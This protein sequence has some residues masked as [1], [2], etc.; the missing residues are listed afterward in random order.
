MI[1]KEWNCLKIK[2]LAKHITAGGTPSTRVSEFWNGDIPWMNSGEINSKNIDSVIRRI[3]QAG[4]KNSSAKMIPPYSVLI[5]LAGQGKTRGTVAINKIKLCTNQSLAAIIPNEK[6]L[7]YYL[8]YNLDFRYQELRTYSTGDGGRGGLNLQIIKNI[9]VDFPTLI[10]EQKKIVEILST[11]DQAIEKLNE[12]ILA[13]EK[14]FKWLLQKL[15]YNQ[16]NNPEWEKVKL[17]ATLSY[18]QPTNYIVHSTQYNNHYNTPVLTAGK[19]FIIGYTNEKDG[20]FPIQKLP[21]IIFDDFTTAKQFVDFPFKVKSSA[22][23]IL[24][25][26]KETIDMK[27]IFY[28]MKN[29]NFQIKSHKRFWISQYSKIKIPIPRPSKQKKITKILFECEKEI[30]ILKQLSNKYHFQK[31]GLMQKLLTGKVRLQ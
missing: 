13:K 17:E 9:K 4:L 2:A 18:E 23:K 11:W 25:P 27:F 3:T 19:T 12:L 29:I 22:M 14:Q 6:I 8:Y 5:A 20:I 24:L 26:K 15:I 16:K 7:P 28:S 21:V 10:D 1:P 30:K 31:R